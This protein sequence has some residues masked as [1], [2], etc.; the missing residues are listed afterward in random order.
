MNFQKLSLIEKGSY[1]N[2]AN[3]TILDDIYNLRL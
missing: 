3:K 2:Q 1:L